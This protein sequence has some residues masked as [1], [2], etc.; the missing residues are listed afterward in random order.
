MWERLKH[1]KKETAC[2]ILPWEMN[3]TACKVS[4]WKELITEIDGLGIK[5]FVFFPLSL[6]TE[7]CKLNLY[8]TL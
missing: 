3:G 1:I 7:M 4:H 8:S 6:K 5:C 2:R